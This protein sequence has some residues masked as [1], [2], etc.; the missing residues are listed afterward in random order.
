MR[1]NFLRLNSRDFFKGM[2]VTFLCTLITGIYQL[3]ANGFEFNW[4]TFKPVVIAA[5]G[6][7]ISYLTKNLFTNSS[8]DFMTWDEQLNPAQ[9][10]KEVL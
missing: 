3:I 4:I 5:V 1:S 10:G 7:G 9:N 2:I 6:S 8:G